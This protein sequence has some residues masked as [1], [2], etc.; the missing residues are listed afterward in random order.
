MI[1]LTVV[2]WREGFFPE[3][4]LTAPNRADGRLD[5]CTGLYES[6][7][8]FDAPFPHFLVKSAHG[9]LLEV[10]CLAMRRRVFRVW[11]LLEEEP[12]VQVISHMGGDV[13]DPPRPL[14]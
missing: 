11:V 6:N 1:W 14:P 3:K 2:L 9:V 5:C 12:V 4:P 10:L 7:Q 13:A 8:I